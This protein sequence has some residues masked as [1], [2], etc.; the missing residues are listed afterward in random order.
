MSNNY[1]SSLIGGGNSLNIIRVPSVNE[2]KNIILNSDLNG[3]TTPSD[4]NTWHWI[5]NYYWWNQNNL[6]KQS[7]TTG[8]RFS[9]SHVEFIDIYTLKDLTYKDYQINNTRMIYLLRPIIEYRE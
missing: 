1:N 6:D 4:V 9:S 3:S 2:A 8:M 5:Q 7:H